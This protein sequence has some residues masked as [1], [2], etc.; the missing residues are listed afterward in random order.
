MSK[1]LQHL[2]KSFLWASDPEPVVLP[3]FVTVVSIDDDLYPKAL[4]AIGPFAIQGVL[5]HI[6]G[7]KL[8]KRKVNEVVDTV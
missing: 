1:S 4:E 2:R 3:H 8:L 7:S 5:D 6:L